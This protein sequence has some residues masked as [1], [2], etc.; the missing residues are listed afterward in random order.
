MIQDETTNQEPPEIIGFDSDGTPARGVFNPLTGV[1]TFP[2]PVNAFLYE[3]VI[4]DE[5]APEKRLNEHN[6]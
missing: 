1:V 6:G 5:T 3:L 2:R 4:C